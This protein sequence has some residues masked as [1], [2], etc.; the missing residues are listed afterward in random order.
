MSNFRV[1]LLAAAM[2]T[3]ALVATPAVA[4]GGPYD[5]YTDTTLVV[6][7]P[8]HPHYD[9]VLEV[10]P[11]FTEETGIEVEVDQ[12]QYLRMRERQ[13]LE[14]T[15]DEGDYDLIALCGVLESRLRVRRSASQSGAVLHESFFG[16]SE[17]QR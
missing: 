12:L 15:Q 6:N 3:T 11:L 2:A 5:A 7:F 16:R 9:A 1:S 17:L 4:D 8:A 13:T 14:L 10:L